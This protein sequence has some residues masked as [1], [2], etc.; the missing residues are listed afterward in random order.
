MRLHFGQRHLE[1]RRHKVKL[2]DTMVVGLRVIIASQPT[3]DHS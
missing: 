3:A 2:G 1:E